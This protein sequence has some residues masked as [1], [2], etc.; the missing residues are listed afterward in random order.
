MT[1][2]LL[3]PWPNW[4]QRYDWSPDPIRLPDTNRLNNCGPEVVAETVK[5]LTGVELPAVYIKDV[6]YSQDFQG[7][8]D[9]SHLA[10][11]FA[12]AD[13]P[14][15]L[16]M[17]PDPWLALRI[18]KAAAAHGHP[19]IS[20]FYETTNYGGAVEGEGGHFC[21]T[22][23]ASDWSVTRSNPWIG[24]QEVMSHAQWWHWYNRRF[25]G[26]LEIKRRRFVGQ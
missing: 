12:S 15:A 26:V 7:Y 13:M 6:M 11:F 24:R 20:L 19:T 25:G 8:T 4:N 21:A 14:A 18:I 10:R 16:T 2:I 17:T 23:G 3:E 22:V 5:Y 9:F 1:P